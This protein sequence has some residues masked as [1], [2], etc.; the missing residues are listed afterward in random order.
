MDKLPE[1]PK[2]T[3]RS[4]S[5]PLAATKPSPAPPSPSPSPSPESPKPSPDPAPAPSPAS[6]PP[7]ASTDPHPSDAAPSA[8]PPPA[9]SSQPLS[10]VAVRETSEDAFK[11]ILC[12]SGESGK[13]TFVRQLKLRFL[14]G[15]D[16]GDREAYVPTIRGNLVEAMQALILWVEKGGEEIPDDLIES[17]TLVS[18]VNAFNCDF[19]QELAD[20]LETLWGEQIIRTAFQHKDETVICDHMDYF[21]PQVQ[22]VFADGYSPTDEDILR[23]RIRSIGIDTVNFDIA[24]AKI[25]IY[26][27]GGQQSERGKWEEVMGSISG[28]LFCVSFADFDKPMFEL[29]PRIEPRIRDSLQI[30]G[31]LTHSSRPNL[32]EAPFFLICNKFDAFK[33][34]VEETDCFIRAFPEFEGN[35]HDADACAEYLAQKFIEEANPQSDARPIIVYRQVALDGE[36]VVENANNICRY[37]RE[38]YFEDVE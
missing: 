5:I 2:Y 19:T 29:L 3:E 1:A 38:H 17:S 9:P 26:D 10:A 11:L 14:G 7:P 23:A 13:T 33:K 21:F 16:Q 37:I 30:F 36:N 28:V 25:C 22:T 31:Q 20:A 15:L 32:Q 18:S 6:A 35:S 24:G 12:G 34:K 4:A 27:V 8:P